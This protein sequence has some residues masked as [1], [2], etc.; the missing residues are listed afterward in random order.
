M[1]HHRLTVIHYIEV[2]Q[3]EISAV[4]RSGYVDR[5]TLQLRAVRSYLGAHRYSEQEQQ[6]AHANK[7]YPLVFSEVFWILI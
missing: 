5:T 2:Y 6:H 1:I 7:K 4:G 3:C